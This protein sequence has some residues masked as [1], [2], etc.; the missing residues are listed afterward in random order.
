MGLLECLYL[1]LCR[2]HQTTQSR[3]RSGAATWGRD[4]RPCGQVGGCSLQ[5]PELRRL[6][7]RRLGR[8]E[9]LVQ[10]HCHLR[11][12]LPRA[13]PRRDAAAQQLREAGA[14][15]G[16]RVR[17]LLALGPMHRRCRLSAGGVGRMVRLFLQ[18]LWREGAAPPHRT[19]RQGQRQVLR[20]SGRGATRGTRLRGL[21]Q[22][23]HFAAH[24]RGSRRLRLAG[25]GVGLQSVA[26]RPDPSTLWA[27]A[28]AQMRLCPLGRVG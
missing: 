6:H 1:Q 19:V 25:R 26:G 28:Q 12:G 14:G 16:R 4:V 5:H 9:R 7:R 17:D 13:A 8:L 20:P 3:H 22:L 10:V 11:R 24:H 27:P 2:R 23:R 21:R 18:L 15:I